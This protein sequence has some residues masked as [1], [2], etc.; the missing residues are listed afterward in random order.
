MKLQARRRS[1]HSVSKRCIRRSRHQILSGAP[2]VWLSTSH[3]CQY[4]YF[5]W[6]TTGQQGSATSNAIPAPA[7]THSLELQAVSDRTLV[8]WHTYRFRVRSE[9]LARRLDT[10]LNRLRLLRLGRPEQRLRRRHSRGR[11]RLAGGR[12]GGARGWW[13]GRVNEKTGVEPGGRAV[14]HERELDVPFPA[15][16]LDVP[17]PALV[18][19]AF[20]LYELE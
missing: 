6:T 11:G 3:R 17:F 5:H 1:W 10:Q 19:G 7:T 16:E 12:L 9:L 2:R 8:Q 13:S 4:M 18:V 15:R 20:G 14:S